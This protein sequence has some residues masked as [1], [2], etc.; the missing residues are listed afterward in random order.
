MYDALISRWV[1]L[2]QIVHCYSALTGDDV[3]FKHLLSNKFISCCLLFTGAGFVSQLQRQTCKKAEISGPSGSKHQDFDRTTSQ[4]SNVAKP[5]VDE[6]AALQ[7]RRN[8]IGRCVSPQTC[9]QTSNGRRRS[10]CERLQP[11][12]PSHDFG[13]LM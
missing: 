5:L 7:L 4:G 1:V 2:S 8:D 3:F 6:L 10:I 13:S 11:Y 9:V 12:F